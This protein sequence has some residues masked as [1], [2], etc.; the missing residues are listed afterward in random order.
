[1]RVDV[2]EYFFDGDLLWEVGVYDLEK[3]VQYG[4]QAAGQ[5]FYFCTLA[6]GGFNRAATDVV[7][8]LAY[9]FN[10]PEPCEPQAGVYAEDAYGADGLLFYRGRGVNILHVVQII[11]RI[12]QFLH[13]GCV[14][15]GQH[16]FSVGFHGNFRHFC[17]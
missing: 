10:D 13:L 3:S 6:G 1:M 4:F 11:Q 5:V 15:A 8:L 16:R 2:D 14:I 17:H 12:Q 9:L 7:Q